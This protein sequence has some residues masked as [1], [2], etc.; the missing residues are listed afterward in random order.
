MSELM[1][2]PMC[3]ILSQVGYR[4]SLPA[5]HRRDRLERAVQLHSPRTV[6]RCLRYLVAIFRVNHLPRLQ[7]LLADKKWLEATFDLTPKFV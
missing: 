7:S 2:P 6:W 1:L 5:V 4:A 3:E